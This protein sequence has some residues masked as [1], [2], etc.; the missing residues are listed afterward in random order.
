[1]RKSLKRMKNGKAISPDD[2]LVEIWKCPGKFLTKLV[3]MILDSE[4]RPEEWRK[5]S[6]QPC[7]MCRVVA[8]TEG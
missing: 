4:K 1:M 7:V 5:S 2:G 8:T 6:F 3:N